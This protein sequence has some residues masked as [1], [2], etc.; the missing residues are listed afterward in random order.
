[1]MKGRLCQ[2]ELD[3]QSSREI[4]T[5]NISTFSFFDKMDALP[6]AQTTVSKH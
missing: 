3:V 4:T 2:L 5:T 6:A 1:M